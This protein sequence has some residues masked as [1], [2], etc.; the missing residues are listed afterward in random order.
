MYPFWKVLHME[1][2]LFGIFP[3]QNV[4]KRDYDQNE[5]WLDL[6]C[7]LFEIGRDSVKT[8][9][10]QYYSSYGICVPLI[11]SRIRMIV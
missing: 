9:Q 6:E 10:E 4:I 8:K 11:S 5:M 2:V 3:F 1:F 7:A